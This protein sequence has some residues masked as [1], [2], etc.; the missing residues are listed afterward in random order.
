MFI[1]ALNWRNPFK[2]DILK[3]SEFMQEAH[4]CDLRAIDCDRLSKD[5]DKIP[6]DYIR[7]GYEYLRNRWQEIRDDCHNIAAKS[8]G[9]ADFE[10]Y[11]RILKRDGLI[12]IGKN[13]IGF[14][15]GV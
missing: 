8:I 2:N 3:W 12:M 1:R 5:S 9:F 13:Q 7:D 14:G 6:F 10:H 4:K 11:E 15:K